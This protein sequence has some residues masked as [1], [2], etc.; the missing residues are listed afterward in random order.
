MKELILDDG[1][2]I[3]CHEDGSVEWSYTNPSWKGYR[4]IRT[5]GAGRNSKGYKTARINQH[6]YAVHRLIAKAFLPNPSNLPQVDHINRNKI[7]NRPK[8][9]RWVDNKKNQFNTDRHDRSK[10]RFGITSCENRDE[11]IKAVTKERGLTKKNITFNDG[12]RHYIPNEDAKV[13]MSIH[14]MYRSYEQY[15]LKRSEYV[16]SI[17]RQHQQ[18]SDLCYSCGRGSERS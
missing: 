7:D 13:L 17:C 14:T 10:A 18:Q 15:K 16:A 4:T 12:K 11:Y 9:L 3:N 5:F 2:K 8:N 6:T 1:T